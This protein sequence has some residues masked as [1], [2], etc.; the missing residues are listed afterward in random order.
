ML[1][2]TF[3]VVVISMDGKKQPFGDVAHALYKV[4]YNPKY[5]HNKRNM[6]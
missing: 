2:C 5:V 6:H 4:R 1:V 3:Y